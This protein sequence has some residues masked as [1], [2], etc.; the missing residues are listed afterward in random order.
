MPARTLLTLT[1]NITLLALLTACGS[2][3]YIIS[4]KTGLMIQAQGK[5]K[6]DATEGVYVYRNAE[7]KEATIMKEDVSQILER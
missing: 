3:P 1:L 5:P 6:F 4:T 7:G 2:T